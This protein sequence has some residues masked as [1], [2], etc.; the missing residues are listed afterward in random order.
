M[1]LKP[2][3]STHLRAYVDASF[4]LHVNSKLHTGAAILIGG[5]LVVFGASRKQ[6]CVTKSPTKS[7]LVALMD[8]L[9]F[10]E[11]F[12]EFL[13]FVENQGRQMPTIYQDSTSVIL[14]VT[15]GGGI[16]WIKQLRV[17]MNLGKEAIENKRVWIEYIGTKKMVTDGLTKPL[18]G[19]DF[20]A[21]HKA[22]MQNNPI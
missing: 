11:L 22:I 19:A 3:G 16:V 15:K 5:A 10:V 13:A 20:N 12:E 1:V 4:A 2:G 6:K 14:L 17:P 18:E 8:N 21:F 7:E 9:D